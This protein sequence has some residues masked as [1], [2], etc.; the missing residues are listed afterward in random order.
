MKKNILSKALFGGFLSF[1]L[2]SCAFASPASLAISS[3]THE[4]LV[5]TPQSV[6]PCFI[7]N[8][9][10]TPA[11]WKLKDSNN[12]GSLHIYTYELISQFWPDP[13]ISNAGRNW[14]HKLTIYVPN[15]VLSQQ[16]LLFINGGTSYTEGQQY[17]PKP[18]KVDFESIATETKTVVADLQDVPNQY[19]RLDDGV[20]RR[21]DGIMAYTWNKYMDDPKDNAY[22]PGH[23]PMVKATVKA[24]DAIQNVAKVHSFPIPQQFVLAGAS[25]RGWAA[26]LTTLV[27][28]RVNGIVPI[29]IDILNTKQNL[30]HIYKSLE[31]WPAA[32]RDY[33]KQ[34]VTDRIETPAFSKLMEIEDPLS[35]MSDKQFKSRLSIPKYIINASSDDFF[36]PD[37]LN[38]YI[39]QLPGENTIRIT[40]NQRHYIDFNVAGKALKDYYKMIVT[41]APRPVIQ[42]NA[43]NDHQTVEITTMFEPKSVKLWKAHNP[44]KRDFRITSNI[45]YKSFNIQGKC[46][47]E[48]CAYHLPK[49][50]KEG[51]TSSFLEFSYQ[52]GEHSLTVTSPAF[53]TPNTYK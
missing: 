4:K 43:S 15:E 26:W 33:V 27:D 50:Q 47:K 45:K 30:T 40:A 35:Y 17:L 46:Q 53:I 41:D 51:Y 42:W 38:Q 32:F 7:K 52:Q 3:C 8:N 31:E 2:S 34:G 12:I 29:V 10:S 14:Q 23:L 21:E 18:H 22:W 6:L 24:M 44:N 39:E 1:F 9:S 36:V 19:L 5:S 11:S 20:A 28:D 37:S 48:R 25:K 13:S 16:S 49:E